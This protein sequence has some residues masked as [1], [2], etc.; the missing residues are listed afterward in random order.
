MDRVLNMCHTVHSHSCEVTLQVDE[1]L[2]RDRHIQ[3]Q[4][5]DLRWSALEKIIDLTIFAKKSILNL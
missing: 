4:V 3:N 2:L 5:K 1:Y